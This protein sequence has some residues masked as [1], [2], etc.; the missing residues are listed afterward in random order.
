[1]VQPLKINGP[2]K[3]NSSTTKIE[4]LKIN[5]IYKFWCGWGWEWYMIAVFACSC[6]RRCCIAI[7]FM[8]DVIHAQWIT[9]TA[10]YIVYGGAS[11]KYW[12]TRFIMALLP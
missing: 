2:L 5:E 10:A 11:R 12:W 3:I 9:T 1:M 4:L 8:L 6:A 7:L